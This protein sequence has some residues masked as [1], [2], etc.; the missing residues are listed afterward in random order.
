MVLK[1]PVTIRPAGRPRGV[2]ASGPAGSSPGHCGHCR[3]GPVEQPG[4]TGVMTVSGE[5]EAMDQ[6]P[7]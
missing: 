3:V 2:S 6:E 4:R 5:G 7:R 1:E